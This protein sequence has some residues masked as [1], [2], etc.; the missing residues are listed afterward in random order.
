MKPH[1]LKSYER[2]CYHGGCGGQIT[3]TKT[4]NKHV[5]LDTIINGLQKDIECRLNDIPHRI[6]IDGNM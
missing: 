3:V 6:Q 2:K 1:P 4:L 5:W